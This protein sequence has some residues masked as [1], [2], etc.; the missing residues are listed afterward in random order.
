MP[1][2]NYAYDSSGRV[3]PRP[4]INDIVTPDANSLGTKAWLAAQD[5][6]AIFVPADFPYC[7][8][9]DRWYFNQTTNAAGGTSHTLRM[10]V[11]QDDGSGQRPLSGSGNLVFNTLSVSS[12][13]TGD[14]FVA[15]NTGAGTFTPPT[16]GRYWFMFCYQPVG[17]PTTRPGFTIAA[18][19]RL[20]LTNST[21]GLGSGAAVQSWTMTGVAGNPTIGTLVESSIVPY[22]GLRRSV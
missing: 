22:F 15:A 13:N 21:N 6:L 4:A 7:D 9:F 18:T 14:R 5:N 2:Q 3:L 8:T 1:V 11:F 19:S 10:A 16:P 20:L 17:T 12:G